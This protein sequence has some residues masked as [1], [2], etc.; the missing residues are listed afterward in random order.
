MKG[1]I[2]IRC[3]GCENYYLPVDYVVR[4]YFE[5][6]QDTDVSASAWLASGKSFNFS[7]GDFLNSKSTISAAGNIV[8]NASSVKNIGAV[9]GAVERTR[10]YRANDWDATWAA[11]YY[12]QYNNPDFPNIYYV[13]DGGELRLATVTKV[14]N[15]GGGDTTYQY[16]TYDVH[17][18]VTSQYMPYYP[19]FYPEELWNE[20]LP[21]SLYN[22]NSLIEVPEEI[23]RLELLSDVEKVMEGGSGIAGRNAV[24]QAGGNVSITAT[25][26]LQNS[27]IRQD[28][29][30]AGGTSKVQGTSPSGAGTAIIR[31]N[32]QLPPDLSQQQVNP[33]T[34]PGFSLPTGQNGL[35]RLSSQTGNSTA[36]TQVTGAPQNWTLGSASVS[37]TQREQT[38]SDT[39]ART[40]QFGT[41]GQVSTTTRQLA[42]VVRQNSGLSANASAFDSS[43]P[44]DSATRLQLTGHSTGNTG[45]T[46]VAD[47]TQVQGQNGTV[48][49]TPVASN[50]TTVQSGITTPTTVPSTQ[51][52]RVQALPGNT[53]PPNPHKYLI[54][55][56]PV[57]TDLRQFMSSDYLLAGLGYDPEASAKRLGDGL[58]EQRLV[59]QAIVARTGQAFLAGQTS[60]EAQL[61]YLMNNAIASKEQLNLT[62]GVALSP[63]QVAALTH[64]IVWLEEH[65]VNGE[66][67]LVPVLYLA[68]AN[69]RLAP[70]GALIAGNDV[71][72]TAGGNLDN[73][74]TLRATNNLSAT[75]GNDLV[76]VGL[77]EAGNRLDLLA[78]NDLTNKAGG[79]LYGRDVTLTATR[80]DVTNE[81]TVTRAVGATGYQDFADSAARVESVNDLTIKAGRDMQNI[82]GTLQAGRDLSLIAGRDLNIGAA[83]TETSKVQGANT[84]SS[85]TQISSNI[86]AG[87]DLIAQSGRDISIIASNLDA[88]RDI[89]MA[90]TENMTLSSAADEQHSST[91]AKKFT[92]QQDLIDQVS[93]SM[94]AGGNVSLG[95]GNSM[96][97][98]ASHI[99]GGGDLDID[100][101]Q[102][103]TIT[104]AVDEQHSYSKTKKVTSQQ[105]RITQVSSTL[106]AGG[107]VVLGSGKDME[108]IASHVRGGGDVDIDAAQDLT[109]TS[110]MDESASFYSKKS[111]GSLGRGSSKQQESYDSTNVAS[112]IE[113]GGDLTVN[114][115]KSADDG[116]VLEGGHNVTV[117]GSQLRAGEDLLVGATNDVA[118]LSGVE[119]HGSY[120]K[121]T[122]SGFLGLSKSGRSQLTTTASQVASELEA[123][124]D[125]VIAAGNDVRLRASETSAGNDVEL[126]AGLVNDI[127]DINL[128]SANDTAYSRSE[129][130]KKKTG[131]STSGG[132]LSISS[133]KEAGREAQSSTS[134]GSNVSADRDATLQATRDVNV[135]GSG[136]SAGRNV[137]LNAGRDVNIAAAQNES[138]EQQWSKNKQVGIGVSGNDNGVSLFIGSDSL[139]EKSRLEQQTAAASQ[140]SAGQDLIINAKRDINQIGSDLN[141]SNDIDLTAGRNINIDAARETQ[142]VEQQ[143]ETER[144]GLGVSLNHNYGK[145][146][147][148]VSGAG[149]GDDAVSQ[150]SST[151]KG[152]DAIGQFLAGPT[153]DV[154]L[155]NSKQST[156][157]EII[158][159]TSRSSTL[160]AGNDVNMTAGNDVT[161][162]GGQLQ[163]GRDINIK[164]RDITLDVAKD[165]ISQES[166]QS[167]SWG[168]IHGGTSGGFKLGIGGSYGVA[169]EDGTYGSSTATQAAAGRDINLDA[170]NNINLVGTQVAAGRDIDL[171]A[172]N[173][174]NIRSAQNESNSESDRHSGGGEVGLTFGSQGVGVYASVSMGKGNL[175]RDSARQQNASLN[176][177]NQLGFTSGNDTNVAGAT[178][179]GDEV[180]GRVGGDLNVSSVTDT[181][182]VEGKEFDINATVTI[183]PGAGISGSVGYGATNGSTN[184]VGQQ[185]SITGKDK[186]DIRTE[187]HTQLDGALIASDSGNLKLDT[188]TLGFSDIVGKDKEHGYYLNV[189]GTYNPSGSTAQDPSQEG[190][191]EK[192]KNGWSVEGW[193]Y[194]KDREQIV[195]ATVGAG[196]VVVRNDAE[197]G[198]DSTAGLNRDVNK[199]YE[200][201]KDEESRTD[202]YVSKSSLEA[203]SDP[204]GILKAWKEKIENYSGNIEFAFEDA[205]SLISG[206]VM[207]VDQVW[208]EVQAQRVSLDEISVSARSKLGDELAL[209]LAKVLVR[210][211]KA[212]DDIDK[213][214]DSDIAIIKNFA[215]KFIEFDSGQVS[216]GG[217]EGCSDE[218]QKGVDYIH[219]RDGGSNNKI[220]ELTALKFDTAGKKMLEQSE[221][222]QFHL[223]SLPVEQAQLLVLGVQ[224]VMGPA[225]MAVGLAGNVLVDRLFGEKL[226]EIKD[227]LAKKVASELSGEDRARLERSDKLIKELYELKEGDQKGDVYVRG[228]TALLNIALGTAV[229]SMGAVGSKVVG[230]ETNAGSP[231][232]GLKIDLDQKFGENPPKGWVDTAPAPRPTSAIPDSHHDVK[233][234]DTGGLPEGGQRVI[235]VAG[236][237]GVAGVA[238]EIPA[239]SAI[240][241]D[242]LREDLATQA[243]IPRNLVDQPSS[244]WG[245]SIDDIKQSFTMDGATVTSVPAK[246]SSSGNAQ[247][248]KVEGS[249]TGIKEFQYSPSTVDNLNQSSHVG[250][251]YKITYEDGSKI[252]VVDPS[253]YRP[254][255]LGSD[256]IYDVNTTYLNPQGQK[257]IFNP[258]NNTWVPK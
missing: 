181:G 25:Q 163:A 123:G 84:Q 212:L 46:Q 6:V 222:L 164:G 19:V 13:G 47:V 243:G 88:K 253:T 8:I 4:E 174:L 65:E 170:S 66:K 91:K 200:I 201:T 16:V 81:R 92:S 59:Q 23:T 139:Q 110:A 192:S 103:L 255:F 72:L 52:A 44:V 50:D 89:A 220:V 17:D 136:I 109:I 37:V 189:G 62:I 133:A 216:C 11:T 229:N 237:K 184:W 191:G 22:R 142:L 76:N 208:K 199:A 119:E 153:A 120:S 129:E 54:E 33:L 98:I 12:N 210:N 124:N 74:G 251:Y 248:F 182:K 214:S 185:T 176:A 158:E 105:D 223:E 193:N 115:S 28:Y 143:R 209:D 140:V 172:G 206:P 31:V 78:G 106:S 183:G 104:S 127:G 131:L 41:A 93:T 42:D 249:A 240:A 197:T 177:G 205:L 166:S 202:L 187:N 195:R 194:E 151:L 57:L 186:V 173:D 10:I 161:V 94:N 75:A 235:S 30:I 71:T 97:I 146:K 190:K 102:N 156:S 247:I 147:D 15:T 117:I 53:A 258:A 100:A 34:L 108:I 79:I 114:T 83:Q 135:L 118:V 233:V 95:A 252:K 204:S 43:T 96:A 162:K 101:A 61:K 85:I 236:E 246:A 99:R 49:F 51:V 230:K 169:S 32:A 148:A 228:A 107:N 38:V 56:N 145:T 157:Q 24:M 122:K 144:S 231:S 87:R 165:S 241:R 55:T 64:D 159:Q 207:A 68:Q 238:D 18:A 128:V 126:R 29:V 69:N 63:P 234:S 138:A 26:N 224:A 141:A 9:G 90:A 82:G 125:V 154:K 36:A 48:P 213:F 226:T 1:I 232:D 239:T 168:G 227:S 150:G 5:G 35:F 250:E 60:N 130:Y 256:P 155:G 39:Q 20:H 198:N 152:I 21:V 245:K 203:V 211:G 58:Y 80:G 121:K 116:I 137:S 134:V 180:V 160:N 225:K 175:D 14:F 257:V 112:I 3:N 167:E 242:G 86:S 221:R 196:E 215:Q 40:L 171:N 217:S 2:A 73:V 7:G 188:G 67:V 45:L 149:Q 77:I 219:Y 244:I 70:N 218:A 111:K 178:L 179:R 254:T 132:F 27:V 113:A